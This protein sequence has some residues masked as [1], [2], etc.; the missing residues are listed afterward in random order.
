MTE[1][2]NGKVKMIAGK[3]QLAKNCL[4]IYFFYVKDFVKNQLI[5]NVLKFIPSQRNVLVQWKVAPGLKGKIYQNSSQM[6]W[7][8]SFN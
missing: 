7:V 5:K 6:A 4:E 3:N 8:R 2:V 1:N